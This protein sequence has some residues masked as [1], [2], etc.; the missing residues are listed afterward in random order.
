MFQVGRW[1]IKIDWILGRYIYLF[2]LGYLIFISFT[3]YPY[4]V[5]IQ[6]NGTIVLSNQLYIY[7]QY[8]V[9]IIVIFLVSTIFENTFKTKPYELFRTTP[10]T[11]TRIIL[12]RYIQISVSIYL[13][14]IIF[15]Q[16]AAKQ[17]N[18]NIISYCIQMKLSEL[19]TISVSSVPLIVQS[20]IVINFFFVLTLFLL[21][22]FQIKSI[23]LVLMLAYC[24]LEFGPMS[25]I[26]GNFCVFRG[27]FNLPDYFHIFSPNTMLLL[28]LS[29]CLF[30]ILF[31]GYSRRP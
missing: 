10:I 26:F 23:P 13:P 24:A 30:L 28:P 9:S 27:A 29:I 7:S 15:L 3:M 4:N 17:I 20:I 22:I 2:Y 19:E 16:D 12:I 11:K 5:E 21:W 31:I 25:R 8:I 6:F 1:S 14:L 18:K